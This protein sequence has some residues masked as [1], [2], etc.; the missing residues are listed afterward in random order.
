LKNKIWFVVVTAILAVVLVGCAEVT[1][2]K[3][4]SY[5]A[6][7]KANEESVQ[8]VIA[9]D[10]LPQI[11]RSLDREISRSVWSSLISLIELGIYICFQVLDS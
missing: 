4:S 5:D 3:P 11:T 7:A 10:T 6:N 1:T 9:N 2:A 8:K